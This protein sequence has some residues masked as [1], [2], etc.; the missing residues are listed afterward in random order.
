M[1]RAAEL[2]DRAEVARLWSAFQTEQ[3]A[4]DPAYRLA[5]D[6]AERWA[7]DF[8]EAVRSTDDVLFVVEKEGDLVGFVLAHPWMPPPL[9]AQT[10]EAFLSLLY[11]APHVRKQGL[12]RDLAQA[13]F[14]WAEDLGLSQVRLGVLAS[15]EAGRAFWERLGFRTF[16]LTALRPLHP[17]SREEPPGRPMGFV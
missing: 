6:A 10:G 14:T 1:I 12:A 7:G 8:A 9:Y 17:T 16:S 11:V 2:G 15:N 13:V 3:Q 5:P 4:L